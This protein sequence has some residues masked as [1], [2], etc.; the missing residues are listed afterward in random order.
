[1]DGIG[2]LIEFMSARTGDLLEATLQH[3]QYVMAAIIT[4]TII[5][6]GIGIWARHR[7]LAREMALGISAV[8]L[9]IPS[10]AL[11]AIFIPA[12]GLGFMPVYLALSMY[13][14]LPIMRNTVVGLTEVSPAVLESARGMGMSSRQRLWRVELPLAWPVII[15]GIRVATLL[16]TGIAAI[17][18]LVGAGGL[19][20]FIQSGLRRLGFP[21]SFESLWAGT[22]LTVALALMFDFLFIFIRRAT[23]SRGIR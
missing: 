13:S 20:V 22:I 21:N 2:A 3:A 17:A 7:P 10:L 5:G 11:F 9:T 12:T 23:T 14:L 15:T 1:M 6:A 8:F 18:I 4:A 19:G 16:S